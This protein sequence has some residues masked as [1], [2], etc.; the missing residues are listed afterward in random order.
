MRRTEGEVSGREERGGGDEKRKST[1]EMDK[2][3]DTLGSQKRH[4]LLKFTKVIDDAVNGWHYHLQ[5]ERRR[6][7]PY[8]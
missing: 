7:S 1:G 3:I 5:I 6:T 8:V 4:H 2:E